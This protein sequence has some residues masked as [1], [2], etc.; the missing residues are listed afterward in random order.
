M[1]VCSHFGSSHLLL[2]IGVRF[3][4]SASSPAPPPCSGLS[5]LTSREES[6]YRLALAH[7]PKGTLFSITRAF[8]APA[9][10]P[11]VNTEAA[12]KK[13]CTSLVDTASRTVAKVAGCT[14]RV[15]PAAKWLRTSGDSEGV[16]LG[17]RLQD[18]SRVRN[19]ECHPWEQFMG[20]LEDYLARFRAGRISRSSG[21]DALS[22]DSGRRMASRVVACRFNSSISSAT[23]RVQRL[24]R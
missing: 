2:A 1:V 7:A 5:K 24:N 10:E 13:R 9:G 11:E 18:L 3:S 8:A 22:D 14:S 15:G 6:L 17:K 19:V 23:I 21:S 4:M 16:A 12:A 20:D